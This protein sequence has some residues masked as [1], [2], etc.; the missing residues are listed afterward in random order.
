MSILVPAVGSV[1]PAPRE[2]D[3]PE[4]LR[5]WLVRAHAVPS[6][7]RTE[8]TK[9]GVALLPLGRKFS[10]IRLPGK[11]VHAA[12]GSDEHQA[13]AELL[14]DALRGPV[15]HDTMSVAHSYYALVGTWSEWV[16]YEDTPLLGTET[17]LGVPDIGRTEP[18]GSYWVV[19][20]RYRH[21]LCRTG[22]VLDFIV[23]ARRALREETGDDIRLA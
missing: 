13:V 20:P 23:Q 17:F 5:S 4:V 18:P 9:Q 2:P 12:A 11:L 16:G 8:W 6:K 7:A 19:A 22:R 14:D 21:V 1:P 3:A 10:A 15:I